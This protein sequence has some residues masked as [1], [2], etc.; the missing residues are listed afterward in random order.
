MSKFIGAKEELQD[1]AQARR[2]GKLAP[3]HRL[4]LR[5]LVCERERDIRKVERF[6]EELRRESYNAGWED[7]RCP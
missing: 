4:L 3:E 7:G 1:G 5:I 6:I 2:Q